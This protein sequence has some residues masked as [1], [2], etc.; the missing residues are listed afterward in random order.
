MMY[1]WIREGYVGL[2]LV[3]SPN[4]YLCVVCLWVDVDGVLLVFC[5]FPCCVLCFGGKLFMIFVCVLHEA[6]G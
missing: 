4:F 2:L 6:C 3:R 5:D 1:E